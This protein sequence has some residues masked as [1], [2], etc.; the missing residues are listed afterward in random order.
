MDH[1]MGGTM[2]RL[3]RRLIFV[4]GTLAATAGISIVLAVGVAPGP[5][6]V[7]TAATGTTG[8]TAPAVTT[9]SASNVRTTS[10]VL[11]G[12]VDPKGQPT[13]WYFQYGPN[14]TYGLQTSPAN[15]GSGTGSVAVHSSVTGLASNTTYHYRLVAQGPGG[16]TFGGDATLTTSSPQ[17]V[18]RF[19]G[20]EGFV[21]PG[22]VIGVE[23]GCFGGDTRCVGHVTMSRNG[24][25]IGQGNF[26]IAPNSGG[27]QNIE[28]SPAGEQMLRS[29]NGVFHLL[30][31]T[32]GVSTTTG[33]QTSQVMHLARWIW[34]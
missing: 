5:P 6:S 17:S 23:A 27:F 22:R 12:T 15:A 9:G 8:A 20:R 33:Q 29:Y 13:T 24:V 26:N 21:S 3:Q 30:P 34:H 18:V 11:N 16:T 31:V 7:A 10:A 25:V 32:V 19:I 4:V 14:T 2:R 28:I 1:Y